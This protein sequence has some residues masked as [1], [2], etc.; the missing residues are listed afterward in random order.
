MNT[1]QTGRILACPECKSP[2]DLGTIEEIEGTAILT[3][4]YLVNG[5][6]EIE[7]EG[8]TDVHWDSS[9]TVGLCCRNCMWEFRGSD[10]EWADQLVV[11]IDDEEFD[12]LAVDAHNDPPELRERA[13]KVLL[14]RAAAVMEPVGQGEIAQAMGYAYEAQRRLEA[15]KFMLRNVEAD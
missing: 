10:T 15:H 6:V 8:T 2:D 1:T 3:G 12:P 4:A 13:I 7:H 5:A 11:D 9:T 14:E